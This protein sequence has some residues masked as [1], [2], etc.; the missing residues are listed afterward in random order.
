MTNWWQIGFIR[1]IYMIKEILMAIFCYDFFLG[2]FAENWIFAISH[3]MDFLFL[4]DLF[5]VFFYLN[6]K[7]FILLK[8]FCLFLMKRKRWDFNLKNCCCFGRFSTKVKCISAKNILFIFDFNVQL[9]QRILFTRLRQT[10]RYQFSCIQFQMNGSEYTHHFN[11]GL[12]YFG[13]IYSKLIFI[14][15][16]STQTFHRWIQ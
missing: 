14:F 6:T 3:V 2:L 1:M 16:N 8:L 12:A 5:R 13:N 10:F 11:N 7:W 9:V 15:Q 4:I